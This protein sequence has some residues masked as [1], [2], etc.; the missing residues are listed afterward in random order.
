[1]ALFFLDYDIRTGHDYQALYAEL[2]KFNA[3][4]V[5][6]SQWCFNRVNTTAGGLRDYFKQ[7]IQDGDRLS[8]VSV[9]DW[10]TQNAMGTPKDL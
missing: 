7:F 1:M 2:A 10:A 6:E 9:D 3:V 8:V 5:L 4:R